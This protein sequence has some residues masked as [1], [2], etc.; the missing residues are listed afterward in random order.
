MLAARP[1]P[2]RHAPI[3]H[4]PGRSAR[5]SPSGTPRF[6][7]GGFTLIELLVVIAIIALLASLLLPAVQQA[8]ERARATQCLNNVKQ[9][10]TAMH[11]YHSGLGSFP[12]G[13][14]VRPPNDGSAELWHGMNIT[15]Q[16]LPTGAALAGCGTATTEGVAVSNYWGW[17]ALLLPQ[18]DQT[19]TYRLIDFG[20]DTSVQRFIPGTGNFSAA[21]FKM[22]SYTCPSAS[23]VPTRDEPQGSSCPD[24]ADNDTGDFGLSNYVG[25]AGTKVQTVDA[26]GNVVNDR[27]GGMFG[28]NAATSFRDV[29][30][31]TVNTI[32]LIETLYG[33]WSEGYHCCTSYPAGDPNSGQGNPP[34]FSAGAVLA[35][36]T[37][38]G[39]GPV[40]GGEV[41]TK[42]GAWHAE[43]VNIALVDGSARLMSY[44]VD[45]DTYRKLIERN[46]GQQIN[47]QW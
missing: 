38:G 13:V 4:A 31:G 33:V 37:V 29:Q 23:M 7:K 44:N 43:G 17:H 24:F 14:I 39:A 1:A 8:R 47:T 5:R 30:D 41:F 34:I 45:R 28:P 18:M 22:P 10:A 11:N 19:P 42:P 36:G 12:A 35:P 40:G 21:T 26:S 16:K 2:V 6:G 20:M 15:G 46:D 32:L 27:V 3:R 9:L 25:G